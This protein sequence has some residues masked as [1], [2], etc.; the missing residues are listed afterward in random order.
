[1]IHFNQI[2]NSRDESYGSFAF[3]KWLAEPQLEE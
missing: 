1:L 3:Q 2:K